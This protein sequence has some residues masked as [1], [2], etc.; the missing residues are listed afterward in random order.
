VLAWAPL[1]HAQ[2]KRPPNIIHIVADDVGYVDLGCFSSKHIQTPIVAV[3][4]LPLLVHSSGV[5]PP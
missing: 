4:L 5:E 1:V 3:L 2:Q